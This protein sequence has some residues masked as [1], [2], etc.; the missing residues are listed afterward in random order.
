MTLG[1]IILVIVVLGS[2]SNWL[3]W[4]FLNHSVVRYLYFVGALV[5][6]SSHALG[7]VIT[8]AK[9]FEFKPFSSEPRVV[10]GK[11]RIPLLGEMLISLAPIAGGLFF[12]YVIDHFVL[13]NYFSFIAPSFSMHSIWLASLHVIKQFNPLYW[14]SWV[15]LLLSLNI[16]AMLGPSFQDIKNM[17]LGLI[18]LFFIHLNS[19]AI[20]GLGAI[21]LIVV[22]IFI[23]I[24]LILIKKLSLIF[25]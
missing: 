10:H 21:T 1:L 7:C 4:K 20:I 15:M 9:I 3:N 16:G 19:A 6:E 12:L 11:S 14:Q 5:H 22:N 25:I 13:G 18:I 8:G 23:Q 17:W 24:V 2:M